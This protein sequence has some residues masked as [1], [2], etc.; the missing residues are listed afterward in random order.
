MKQ[1]RAPA[2]DQPS[3]KKK[4]KVYRAYTYI[5]TQTHASERS[6]ETIVGFNYH[7]SGRAYNLCTSEKNSRS[8]A[9]PPIIARTKFFIAWMCI[10]IG[11]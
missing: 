5:Q 8:N 1:H 11:A 2:K 9:Q 7:D 10:V 4:N 3:A 6:I